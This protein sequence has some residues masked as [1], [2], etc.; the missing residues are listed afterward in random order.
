MH[1]H[2]RNPLQNEELL[3]ILR[4]INNNPEMTQ[5]ELSYKLGISLGKINFLL[6]ASI[7]RGLIKVHNFKKSNNKAAYLYYLT[8]Q[9]LEEKTKTAYYFLK[10]KVQEYEKL[11]E[12]IRQL[13]EE[14]GEHK[15]SGELNDK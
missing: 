2:E 14:A 3:K 12:E 9:G 8:P 13:A 1:K 5:R 6:K 15:P 10:R 11:E 7:N 4:E